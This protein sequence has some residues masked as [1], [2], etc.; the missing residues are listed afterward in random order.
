ME[1]EDT[2]FLN[3]KIDGTRL[4]FVDDLDNRIFGGESYLDAIVGD[5]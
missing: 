2:I 5:Q 1:R 3:V 4:D